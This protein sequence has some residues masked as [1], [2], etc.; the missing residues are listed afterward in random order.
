MFIREGN[1]VD[2]IYDFLCVGEHG[3]EFHPSRTS[4]IAL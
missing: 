3:Y 2:I 1:A 4:G